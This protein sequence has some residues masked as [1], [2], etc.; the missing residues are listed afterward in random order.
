MILE[1]IK[2]RK[3]IRKFKEKEIPKEDVERLISALMLAP[4]AGNLQ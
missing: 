3:S 4:S 1:I 2:K